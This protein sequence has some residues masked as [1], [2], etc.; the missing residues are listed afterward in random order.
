[1]ARSDTFSNQQF[2]RKASLHCT[3][4]EHASRINGDWI[5]HVKSDYLAYECPHCGTTIN[6]RSDR[7]AL[8]SQSGDAFN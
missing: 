1:M 4:C 2:S 3:N 8:A 7:K 6:S 5:I